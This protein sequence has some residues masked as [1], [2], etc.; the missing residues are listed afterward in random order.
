MQE[1]FTDEEQAE[2]C[3]FL[4]YA[5]WQSLAQSI[6]LG[7]PA[8]GEPLFLVL[9]SFKRIAPAARPL[10]RRDLAEL[11]CIEDQLSESRGRLRAQSVEGVRFNPLEMKGLLDH[12]T[13]WRQRLE[14]DLGVIRNPFSQASYGGSPG[15]INA[16]V[17]G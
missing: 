14:D 8:A 6:Q 5:N 12:Q 15:G 7:Y 3:R 11:R 16:K 13:Y 1:P 9:D 17:S 4:G 10:V 2:I